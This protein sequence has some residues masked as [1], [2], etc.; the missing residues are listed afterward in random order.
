[1]PLATTDVS[2]PT[3]ATDPHLWHFD[4]LAQDPSYIAYQEELRDLIFLTATHAAPSPTGTQ[5][6]ALLDTTT[7]ETGSLPAGLPLAI[8]GHDKATNW[9]A[10]NSSLEPDRPNSSCDRTAATVISHGR[11]FKYLQ[12][13][14]CQVAPWLDMFDSRHH[15]FGVE[16]PLLAHRSSA[17][18]YAVLALSAR[19]KERL[20]SLRN[21]DGLHGTAKSKG[22]SSHEAV[23]EGARITGPAED[24]PEDSIAAMAANSSVVRTSPTYADS[25]ELYQE[26]ICLL[27]PLLQARDPL[28][29][30]ICTVLCVLE[31]MSASAQD[32]RRHLEGC[33]ALFDAFRVHGFSGGLYQAVFWCYA[34]MG[35]K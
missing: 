12:N 33:A 9:I 24:T 14:I 7:N 8:A 30:P 35:T 13:Y 29:V 16:V 10:G 27:R 20:Q 11:R 2:S 6:A 5:E 1:M 28:S 4:A 21:A 23:A 19:Q 17:L 25:L 26:A 34:R 15:I 3:M 22:P 31:M 32:W 18:L